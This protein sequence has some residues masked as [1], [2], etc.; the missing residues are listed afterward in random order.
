MNHLLRR[1]LHKIYNSNILK[2]SHTPILKCSRIYQSTNPAFPDDKTMKQDES[3]KIIVIS[4]PKG[5]E[6]IYVNESSLKESEE[7]LESRESL[8][9]QELLAKYIVKKTDA[10]ID[11]GSIYD[12][13]PNA[14]KALK[15]KEPI[16]RKVW[17]EQDCSTSFPASPEEANLDLHQYI[18]QRDMWERQQILHIPKFCVGSII[19]VTRADQWSETGISKFVGLCIHINKYVNTKEYAFT[20]RNVIQGEPLEINFPF[21]NPLIQK[22]EVL[23]HER[24][25]NEVTDPKEE[26]HFGLQFLRDYPIE[27]S[28]VDEKMKAEPYTEEPS[29]RK[30]TDEDK[31][32]HVKH[33]SDVFESRK[34]MGANKCEKRKQHL[35]EM[36]DKRNP[37]KEHER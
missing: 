30:W 8:F 31:E 9:P 21:Y 6:D 35:K 2:R 12:E 34:L 36:F 32:K 37:Y 5:G 1:S 33:L 24:W 29:I 14:H 27:Y 7:I 13:Y 3:D 28:I 26:Y 19:A 18:E 23:R 16:R 25:E 22:I 17:E 15:A 10:S 4:D 20:L 11:Y